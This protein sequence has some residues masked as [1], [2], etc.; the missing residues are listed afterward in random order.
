MA[1]HAEPTGRSQS[2]T[3]PAVTNTTT[4]S[5][6]TRPFRDY[7]KPSMLSVSDMKGE[8]QVLRVLIA[9]NCQRD[10]AKAESLVVRFSNHPKI[11]TRAICDHVTSRLRHTT[12]A[13]DNKSLE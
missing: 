1:D 8:H 6:R 5:T 10:V 3:I 7:R 12:I 9:A 4:R 11:E 2:V 13:Y